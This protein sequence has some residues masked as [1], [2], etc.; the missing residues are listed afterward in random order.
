MVE[1]FRVFGGNV[2]FKGFKGVALVT[3]ECFNTKTININ[4]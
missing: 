4:C 2:V 1:S 3:I